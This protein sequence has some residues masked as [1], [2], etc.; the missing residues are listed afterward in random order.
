MPLRLYSAI[1]LGYKSVNYLNQLNFLRSKVGG[2][3]E[4]RGFGWFAG[5]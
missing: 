3:W 1:K 5:V 2:Y 4:E